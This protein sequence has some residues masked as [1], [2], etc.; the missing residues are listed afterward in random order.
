[1]VTRETSNPCFPASITQ[2][3]DACNFVGREFTSSG[4]HPSQPPSANCTRCPVPKRSPAPRWRSCWKSRNSLSKVSRGFFPIIRIWARTSSRRQQGNSLRVACESRR[5]A[6]NESTF[7]WS[8]RPQHWAGRLA[9][10]QGGLLRPGRE[11]A[12]DFF[13]EFLGFVKVPAGTSSAT[14]SACE[15]ATSSPK[16]TKLPRIEIPKFDDRGSA[17]PTFSDLFTSLV[18]KNPALDDVQQLYHLKVTLCQSRFDNKRMEVD[19]VVGERR[20][21]GRHRQATRLERGSSRPA[22]QFRSPHGATGRSP[23]PAGRPQPGHRIPAGF[24]TLFRNLH[25]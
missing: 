12:S 23:R 20:K 15:T 7:A 17:W 21:R 13:S 18:V 22:R 9:V 19:F 3:I 16:G 10:L 8:S 25:L 11:Q 4:L 24:G 5:S 1:M 2:K 6:S 14:P